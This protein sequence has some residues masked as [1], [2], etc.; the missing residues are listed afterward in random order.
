MVTNNFLKWLKGSAAMAGTG[1]SL[2]DLG[3]TLTATDGE[4]TTDL[5]PASNSYPFQQYGGVLGYRLN[6]ETDDVIKA[7]YPTNLL[8]G[9][10]STTA[11]ADDIALKSIITGLTNVSF[12]ASKY[13]DETT[14]KLKIN[15]TRV[16]QN[17]T[18]D[19]IS[20]R[21]VALYHCIRNGTT[22]SSKSANYCFAREA[23]F[24]PLVVNKG[25]NFTVS[26]TIEL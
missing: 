20:V 10:D 1:T 16:F 14:Q 21:E 7:N 23:L 17:T 24:S 15:F 5:I 3:A 8:V 26:M 18:G 2:V 4:T 9:S 11:T 6:P 13:Y 25:D 12:V 19:F 22:T